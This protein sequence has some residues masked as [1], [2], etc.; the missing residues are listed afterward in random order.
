MPDGPWAASTALDGR[1][2]KVTKVVAGSGEVF[3]N[4]LYF[5]D[6]RFLSERCQISCDFG[7]TEYQ[8][9]TEGETIH[10]TVTTRCEAAPFTVVW[11]GRIT[12][13]DITFDGTWT[14]RRWYW[15]QQIAASGVGTLEPD[16]AAIRANPSV[17]G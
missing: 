14:T 3:V 17:D 1:T 6:G 8:T 12:G 7:W 11:Y 4:D 15:T 2:F 16:V 13:D 9:H 10:F 5:A